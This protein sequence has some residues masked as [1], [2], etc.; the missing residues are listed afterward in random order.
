MQ[1]CNFVL[2]LNK[3][4]FCP[5]NIYSMM[6]GLVKA[7]NLVQL[8]Y[9]SKE[10]VSWAI[11]AKTQL[12]CDNK[13][14]YTFQIAIDYNMLSKNNLFSPFKQGTKHAINWKYTAKIK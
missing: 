6:L 2:K 7:V 4:T 11:C 3:K 13:N 12:C 9:F 14:I 1:Q 10:Y 5:E 8:L